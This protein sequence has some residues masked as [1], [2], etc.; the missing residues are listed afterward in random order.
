MRKPI[1]GNV[2][3]AITEE[4]IMEFRELYA[5][6]RQIK[7]SH[8][9]SMLCLGDTTKE[10]RAFFAS[11]GDINNGRSYAE[12]QAEVKHLLRLLDEGKPLHEA[13]YESS[14]RMVHIC[15][16]PVEKRIAESYAAV[17]GM[18]LPNACKEALFERIEAEPQANELTFQSSLTM[19]Q[20]ERNFERVDFF[21]ELKDGLK[22]AA[23]IDVT[24]TKLTPSYHGKECL[25]NGSWVGYECC[26]DE[27]D[28]YLACFPEAAQVRNV[29]FH[30]SDNLR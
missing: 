6:I 19:E 8:A 13:Q 20:I 10:E 11:V 23:L 16:S 12:E 4:Q 15:L 7:Y 30:V 21:A 3:V 14:D 22:E 5:K 24:G 25:G 29:P 9:Y 17:K 27:C 26:C 2:P 28:F 18:T 1:Y